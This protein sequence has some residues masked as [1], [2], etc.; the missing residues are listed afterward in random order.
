MGGFGSAAGR[1][2]GLALAGKARNMQ[3]RRQ[4]RRA[5]RLSSAVKASQHGQAAN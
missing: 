2:Q 4:P 3:V 5:P 1:R